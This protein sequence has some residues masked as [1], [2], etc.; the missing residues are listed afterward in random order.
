MQSARYKAEINSKYDSGSDSRIGYNIKN[1]LLNLRDFFKKESVLCISGLLAVFSMLLVPP[2]VEYGGY[3]DLRVL[4]LLFCLMAVVVGFQECGVF[5]ILAQKLLTGRKRLHILFLILVMLPFFCSMLVTNDVA[6]ITFVPFTIIILKTID[7]TEYLIWIIIL[8][9]IA[10]NLGSMA[11]PVGN[12]QNLFLYAKYSLTPQD[13]FTV[14][15]P[16]TIV[17][18]LALFIPI[19]FMKRET[20]EVQFDHREALRDP[21]RFLLFLALFFLCLLSVFRVLHY[22][23]LLAAVIFCLMLFDHKLF[24]RVDYALLLTFVFFF[25][26]AGNMG[27]LEEVR[28][29]IIALIEENALFS[30]LLASQFISNVPAAVLMANFTQD[31]HGLLLGTNIG[32]LGTPIA[33]LA[34]LIS[35]KYYMKVENPKPLHYLGLFLIANIAGLMLLLTACQFFFS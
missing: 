33:S 24:Q 2:S 16:L 26:F 12:P 30:S 35:L 28:S 10:A 13:F 4:S 20:I 17:S 23:I 27:Q 9:T 25:I 21:K 8:Q 6:L 34:S 1:V 22:G 31:W 18:L 3:I 5:T 11:M 29:I 15:V 32:G 19:F 7:R 14:M